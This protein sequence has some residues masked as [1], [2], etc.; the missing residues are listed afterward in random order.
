MPVQKY[1][2]TKWVWSI[3]GV[4]PPQT[5]NPRWNPGYSG[6]YADEIIE[7]LLSYFDV[8]EYIIKLLISNSYYY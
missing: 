1:L 3:K 5:R 6:G 7:T 4:L 2:H 8:L